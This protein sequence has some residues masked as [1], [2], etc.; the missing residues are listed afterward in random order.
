MTNKEKYGIV[1]QALSS[2][3][4]NKQSFICNAIESSS[5]TGLSVFKL[6]PELLEYKPED[7]HKSSPW[8]NTKEDG[9]KIRIKILTELQLRFKNIEE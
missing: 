7:K 4:S 8:W 6:I 1:T 9:M 5:D 2:I 3:E